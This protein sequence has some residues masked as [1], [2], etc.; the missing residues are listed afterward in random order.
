MEILLLN[1]ITYQAYSLQIIKWLEK[2]W[3]HMDIIEDIKNLSLQT[4]I[5]PKVFI[6]I[7]N[8]QILGTISLLENDMNI[9]PNLNPWLGCLYVDSKYRKQGIANKLFVH[10]ENY[11]TKLHIKTLYLFT[12]KLYKLGKRYN[13]HT[14][15]EVFFENE[16]VTIMKKELI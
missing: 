11:A 1:D 14:I 15:E 6:A 9:R 5:F 12:S 16:I 2:E 7:E 10:C 4:N 8:E 3:G 13:W